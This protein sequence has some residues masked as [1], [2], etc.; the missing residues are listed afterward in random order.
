VDILYE[1]GYDGVISIEHEDPVWEGSEEKV[2]TGIL[3]S[4]DHIA[5]FLV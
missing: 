5:R 3:I 2:K 4:R 1:I